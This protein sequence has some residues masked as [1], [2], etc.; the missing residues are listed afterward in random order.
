MARMTPE[1]GTPYN[2]IRASI[3]TGKKNRSIPV[4]SH[5]YFFFTKNEF[6]SIA[7]WKT[8]V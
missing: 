4:F 2:G 5:D 7:I 8:A 1:Q 3:V 6:F